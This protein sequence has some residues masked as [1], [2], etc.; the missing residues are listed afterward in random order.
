VVEHGLE[1]FL[2]PVG[3]VDAMAAAALTVLRD[4]QKMAQMRTAARA[5]AEKCFR[6]EILVPEY[7]AFYEE[8]LNRSSSG[9]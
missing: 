8:I 2:F 3:D 5:K 4:P 1:G 7:E 6:I 9:I